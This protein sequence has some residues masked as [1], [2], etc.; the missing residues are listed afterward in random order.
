MHR[1]FVA[2]ALPPAI[3]RQLLASSGGIP[4]ARWQSDDQLHLTLRFIGE[5]DRHAAEDAALALAAIRYPQIS[6]ALS[7][8]GQFESRGRPNAVWAGVTPHDALIGLHKKVDQA[9][10]RAGQP[11]EARAY[12]PHVTLARMNAASGAADK[13][14]AQ[15]AALA[16]AP[17]VLTHFHLYESHLGRDGA[18][19]EAVERYAL[20]D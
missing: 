15:H 8:V 5:V 7:G 9:L 11:P 17:F 6:I 1:L 13:F 14:L 10:I 3:R 16:S 18:S 19:Y 20:G 2:F 12:L 4:G